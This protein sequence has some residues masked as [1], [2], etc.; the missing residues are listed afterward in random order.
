[1]GY[2]VGQLAGLAGVSV[3]TLHHYDEVGRLTPVGRTAAGYRL[4]DDADVT[5]LRNVLTYRERIDGQ[6]FRS[7]AGRVPLVAK[8]GD[9]RLYASKGIR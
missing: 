7:Y 1:M 8:D 6:L 5:R 2:S 3:R 9:W 4:Y